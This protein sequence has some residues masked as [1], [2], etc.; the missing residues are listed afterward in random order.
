MREDNESRKKVANA[1]SELEISGGPR[2][3]EVDE[4]AS[5]VGDM[6]NIMAEIMELS[7]AKLEAEGRARNDG[8]R[9]E[10]EKRMKIRRQCC[11]CEEMAAVNSDGKTSC[12]HHFCA[13]C[14]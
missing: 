10:K 2:K 8:K 3:I 11:T 1:P 6:N 14:F 7:N 13:T 12:C 5:G 9:V 4:E